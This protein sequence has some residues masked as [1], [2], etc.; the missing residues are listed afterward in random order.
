MSAPR[1]PQSPPRLPGLTFVELLGSGGFSDVFAYRQDGLDREVAVKVMLADLGPDLARQFE[2]EARTM[3]KLSLHY[4]VV[5]V[6][7]AGVAPDGRSYLVMQV[8]DR[9]SLA[10]RIR[11]PLQVGRALDIAI[12]IAGAIETAHRLGIVH[13]DIKPANILFITN[14]RPALTDFGIAAHMSTTGGVNAFSVPWAPPEQ[15]DGHPAG[16]GADI[17]GLAATTFAML[18]GRSPFEIPGAANDLFGVAQRVRRDPAPRTGRPDVPESLEQI[19]A[20]ALAKQPAQRY[21]SAVEFAHA[22]QGV[23]AEL[24]LPETRI[25]VL[26]D[27]DDDWSDE[28]DDSGTRLT[29][30]AVLDPDAG[31]GGQTHAGGVTWADS[32]PPAP[33]TAGW[34]AARPIQAPGEHPWVQQHGAGSA[35]PRELHFTGTDVPAARPSTDRTEPTRSRS[36]SASRVVALVA[37][38]A[39]LVAAAIGG[40]VVLSTRGPRATTGNDTATTTVRPA[41]PVGRVVPRPIDARA[42]QEGADVVV[43]WVNPAPAEG[44]YYLYRVQVPGREQASSRTESTTVRVPAEPGRT[45]VEIVLTRA[46][47]RD[48]EPAVACTE[49]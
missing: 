6:Y 38:L 46:N 29:S 44:D 30:F 48:S 41:D 2:V 27:S 17:Y 24:G 32:D 3:A 31:P 37:G 7:A 22:L 43:T 10:A 15:L 33:P 8:C 20:I 5:P 19:L 34:L 47:G 39:L 26:T 18:T 25:D 49:A 1:S 16:P 11:R 13:R 12:Q 40:G 9:R 45:C 4:C 28:N 23:Q 21:A 14:Q 36:S 35:A 42:V